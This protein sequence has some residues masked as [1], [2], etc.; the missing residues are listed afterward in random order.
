[1]LAFARDALTIKYLFLSHIYLLR[2]LKNL[3]TQK[4]ICVQKTVLLKLSS[5]KRFAFYNFLLLRSL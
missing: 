4:T 2:G 1:M 5:S 3:C